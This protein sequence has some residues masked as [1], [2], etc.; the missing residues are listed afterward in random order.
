MNFTITFRND[1]P[2]TI[3]NVLAQKLGREPTNEEAKQEV[4]RIL[5][6]TKENKNGN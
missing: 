3:W 4:I 2:D 1:N 6:I 5:N